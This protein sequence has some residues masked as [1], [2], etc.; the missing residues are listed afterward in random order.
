LYRWNVW[1]AAFLIAG[2]C[3]DD[4]F[5]DF[6][7]GLIAQ[8][9]DWY[10]KVEASPDSLADHPAAA[11]PGD[12]GARGRW[13]SVLF[14]EVVNYAA[15]RAFERLTGDDHAFYDAW[16]EYDAAREHGPGGEA[17]MGE[18][19]DFNDDEQMRRRLPRLF[20]LCR[21]GD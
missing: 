17:G 14:Y 11:A 21:H 4:S 5:I 13:E 7:A 19:F 16:A 12:P 3:S 2:G 15:P 1:A 20:V 6:R 10:Q 9:R 8:G 18:D